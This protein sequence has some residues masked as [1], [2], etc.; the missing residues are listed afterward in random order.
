VL[1]GNAYLRYAEKLV[2]LG[3]IDEAAIAEHID[4]VDELLALHNDAVN[5]V[6]PRIQSVCVA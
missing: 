5:A 4:S 6:K 3:R 1:E 2:T